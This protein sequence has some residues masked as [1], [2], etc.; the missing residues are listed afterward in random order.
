M[1]IVSAIIFLLIGGS[2]IIFS[3]PMGKFAYNM[4]FQMWKDI[5]T[6]NDPRPKWQ[7]YWKHGEA[8]H[9]WINRIIGT[10]CLIASVILFILHFNVF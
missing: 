3:S 8:L 2:L 9:I 5:H 7:L 4:N 6:N 1:E 10:G